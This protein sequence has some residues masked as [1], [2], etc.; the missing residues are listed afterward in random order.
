MLYQF[1]I[2]YNHRLLNIDFA[3]LNFGLRLF[4]KRQYKERY[5]STVPKKYA[6]D[7]L[8]SVYNNVNECLATTILF[9]R[10]FFTLSTF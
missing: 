7:I 1:C 8:M 10:F 3:D 2:T 6:D 4:I 9:T 5:I